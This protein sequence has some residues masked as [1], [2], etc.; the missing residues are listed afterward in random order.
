MSCIQNGYNWD[1]QD[2]IGKD[3]IELVKDSIG[4]KEKRNIKEKVNTR[5]LSE[6]I[7]AFLKKFPEVKIDVDTEIL[8]KIDIPAI[9]N[10]AETK[11]F[12]EHL[13]QGFPLSELI[14]EI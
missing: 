11:K 6:Q 2:S 13:P 1:T 7:M 5:K 12:Y 3:S 4:E 9:E 14:K 10:L 8:K